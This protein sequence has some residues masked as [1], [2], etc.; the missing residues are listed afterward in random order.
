MTTGALRKDGRDVRTVEYFLS[1]NGVGN[2]GGISCVGQALQET[3]LFQ[4]WEKG[5]NSGPALLRA[6][7]YCQGE[8]G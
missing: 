1:G 5:Q 6:L 2:N 3:N 7:L 4:M 8:R